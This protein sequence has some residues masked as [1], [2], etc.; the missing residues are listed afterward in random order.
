MAVVMLP[1]LLLLELD[2]EAIIGVHDECIA[3]AAV[4]EPA[5]RGMQDIYY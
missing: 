4:A 1:I 5:G 2:D 3:T